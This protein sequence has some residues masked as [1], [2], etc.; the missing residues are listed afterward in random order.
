MELNVVLKIYSCKVKIAIIYFLF[1][2]GSVSADNFEVELKQLRKYMIQGFDTSINIENTLKETHLMIGNQDVETQL[3]FYKLASILLLDIFS[4]DSKIYIKKGLD[5]AKKTNHLSKTSFFTIVLNLLNIS[6]DDLV[7][8]NEIDDYIKELNGHEASN[9]KLVTFSY[10]SQNCR[11]SGYYYFQLR[12]IN[13]GFDTFKSLD[14][15]NLSNLRF[16]AD[17]YN[18]LG[19]HYMDVNDFKKAEI[20]L[21]SAVQI[22]KIINNSIRA[23]IAL[24]NIGISLQETK[25]HLKAAEFFK[26]T[27][28][29]KKLLNEHYGQGLGHMYLS[30]SFLSLN[31]YFL[32]EKHIDT[33]I[34][35]LEEMKAIDRLAY[36]Y[37]FKAQTSS[38]L[39]NSQEAIKFIKLSLTHSDEFYSQQKQIIVFDRIFKLL[40]NIDNNSIKNEFLE[41]FFN[42]QNTLT[43][44]YIDGILEK[45]M[46][47]SKL[48]ISNNENTYLLKLGTLNKE[49]LK[50]EET[51]NKVK[52]QWIFGLFLLTSVLF[53]SIFKQIKISKKYK[54]QALV[55]YLTGLLNRRAYFNKLNKVHSNPIQNN[56]RAYLLVYDIDKF[57]NINDTYG[58]LAGDEILISLGKILMKYNTSNS[59]VARTG[60]EEFASVYFSIDVEDIRN[61]C[62]NLINE[63]AT[64]ITIY[65]NE[66]IKIS[67]SL[68]VSEIDGGKELNDIINQ[69]DKLM[70]LAKEKGG[71]RYE[72]DLY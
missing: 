48:A 15:T 51:A 37:L 22:F 17:L 36:A 61:Y 32:A 2:C 64:L 41:I 14:Q 26:K 20:E 9:D 40:K 50:I 28:K 46:A 54:K 7:S 58:H 44:S 30:H 38:A 19:L 21:N 67:V 13:L 45:A 25:Q 66:E 23:S 29:E 53:I 33:A 71:N 42:K 55:D 65:K 47:E 8:K 39:G 16:Q 57:K 49:S 60:G 69:T 12:A 68:G 27:I 62:E 11:E 1:V 6:K 24:F 56:K 18:Q 72:D 43:Q 31:K 10:L 52:K 34:E 5:L 35:L 59:F 70:Y 63:I 4:E 3:E